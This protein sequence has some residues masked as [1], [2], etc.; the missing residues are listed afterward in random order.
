MRRCRSP[1]D[2]NGPVSG[3]G[4]HWIPPRRA[5]LKKGDKLNMRVA[6]RALL[7]PA[8]QD[9]AYLASAYR[10]LPD[11][12]DATHLSRIPGGLPRPAQHY[13]R[14][15]GRTRENSVASLATDRASR[16]RVCAPH[17]CTLRGV[18]LGQGPGGEGRRRVDTHRSKRSCHTW[19]TWRPWSVRSVGPRPPP[20]LVSAPPP[21]PAPPAPG[22]RLAP[23]P[24]RGLSSPPPGRQQLGEPQAGRTCQGR[25]GPA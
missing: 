24:G 9:F 1:G 2:L 15:S 5:S 13:L 14:A 8:D 20:A 16:D 25:K 18:A 6:R 4:A 11:P 17:L 3:V 7:A 22:R 10:A 19:D 23:R 21:A 12:P